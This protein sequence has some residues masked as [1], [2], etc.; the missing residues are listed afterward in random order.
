VNVAVSQTR[1]DFSLQKKEQKHHS[2]SR[3]NMPLW[4]TKR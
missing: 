3:E 4:E 1:S 2:K